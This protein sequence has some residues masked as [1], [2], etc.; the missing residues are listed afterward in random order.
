MKRASIRFYYSQ[1]L[2]SNSGLDILNSTWQDGAH[3]LQ[4]I[5]KIRPHDKQQNYKTRPDNLVFNPSC[6]KK[7]LPAKELYAKVQNI[8]LYITYNFK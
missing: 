8:Y 7:I 5:S 6:S 3:S 1:S 4:K 2:I